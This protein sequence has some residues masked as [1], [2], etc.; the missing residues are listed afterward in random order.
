MTTDHRFNFVVVLSKLC[1]VVNHI[2]DSS[3]GLLIKVIFL[4]C[5][6]FGVLVG[7]IFLEPE[8]SLEYLLFTLFYFLLE[9]RSPFGQES[10][11]GGISHIKYLG[12]YFLS[13]I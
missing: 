5:I 9:F 10:K 7:L 12:L 13:R 3:F 1:S 4:G 11:N 2:F 6:E 8:R